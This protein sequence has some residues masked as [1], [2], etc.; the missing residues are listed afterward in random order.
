[1]APSWERILIVFVICCYN[2]VVGIYVSP[3]FDIYEQWGSWGECSPPCGVGLRFRY[4]NCKDWN[5]YPC[6]DVWQAKACR[7]KVCPV[8]GKWSSWNSWT[9]CPV[10]CGS[11]VQSRTR[12]CTNPAPA[13]GG[14]NCEGPSSET[15][16]CA[17]NACPVNGNW[18]AWSS[19]DSCSAT[20]GGGSQSRTRACTNPAPSNGGC[21]C[22]GPSSETQVCATNACPVNGKWSS[23]NSWTR[24]PV[25]CGSGVQ[26]RTRDC[27]RNFG[28]NCEGPSS[29]TQIC[30]TNACPVNGN[31]TA[32]SSWDS[33]SAT[34]GGGSQS[35]TRECTNP[36]PVNGGR[37]CEGPSS[38]TQ[39][40]ATN[41]CPVNGNWT[42]WSSWDSCSATCGGGSQSRTR[43]CTN[44][45]PVNGGSNCEGPSSETQICA[46]NACPV[47]G[48]WTAWSSWDSCSVSCGGGNQ[49]R[50]RTCTNPAPANG[51]QSCE[52]PS[53]Q[54]RIC[55]TD[56]CPPPVC[57]V[58]QTVTDRCGQRC[59]CGA[60][61]N[62]TQCTRI[63]K[64]FTSMTTAER[65]RYISVIKTASTD[66]RYKSRYDTLLT[67]HKTL[68]NNGD[69]HHN[70]NNFLPWH[71]WYDLEYENL[72]REVDCQFTVAYWD[73]VA[74][75]E[76]PWNTR[77]RALW[78]SGNSGMG[79]NGVQPNQC[80]NTG[81]FREG[82]WQLIPSVNTLPRC[83]RRN[84]NKNPPNAVELEALL[85]ISPERFEGFEYKLRY[86]FTHELQCMI[87]GTMCSR[88]AA[89]APEFFL[90]QA[91]I[92]KI[93]E[94][95][96]SKSNFHRTVFFANLTTSLPGTNNILPR[97]LIDNKALP[98]GVRV[99]Y[100]PYNAGLN[101]MA[102]SEDERNTRA[103]FT[104]M[105]KGLV[106]GLIL[107]C[108]I[109]CQSVVSGQ[110]QLYRQWGAWSSCS[111][112]CGG[113]Y[114]WRFRECVDWDNWNCW[115][116]WQTEACNT[117]SCGVVNG[118]WTA[119]SSWSSCSVSCGGGSQSRTRTCT[120]PAPANGGSN[121]DGPSS[122][123]Q[124]C[125]QTT[126]P[127]PIHGNWTEWSSWSS[128]SVSCGG[129]SQSRTRTC[130]NPPPSNGGSNC[131]GPSSETQ[132]CGTITCPPRCQVGQTV[133][134]SC[135]QRCVCGAGG[136]LTQ[137]TR[138]RKEFTSMTTAERERHISVIK[139]A[140]TDPR[141]KPRYDALITMHKEIFFNNGIHEQEH[142]LT[143][144]RWYI[145]T[146]ENLLREVDCNFTVA[147][148]D[149]AAAAGRPWAT[150]AQDVWYS[151]DSGFGGNGV[152]PEECVNTGPFRQGVW[153][154]VPPV[155]TPPNCLKR[156][157]N[158]NPEGTVEIQILLNTAAEDFVDFE[159]ALRGRFH[160]TV[161]CLIGGTMCEQDSAAAPE[162]F[163]HHGFIDKIWEDWQ[164]R[165]A[166]HRN[167]YF[168][169]LNEALPRSSGVLPRE[170]LDN[171]ALPGGVRAEYQ[172]IQNSELANVIS[173]LR[174]LP[175]ARLQAIPRI[176]AS[177]ISEKTKELFRLKA[178]EQKRLEELES[179]F[180]PRVRS[181]SSSRSGIAGKLG[182]DPRVLDSVAK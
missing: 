88:D 182:F 72:L 1:M 15:Q 66:P 127:T 152:A 114:R 153:S 55:A 47:N 123:T 79:G 144:H 85:N 19:W 176:G 118:N 181:R 77:A 29:E 60:G 17:T 9:R 132:E 158:D 8:H 137:C 110:E 16:I 39:I 165:S 166:A 98:G 125:S 45:A 172:P 179:R 63:R 109:C 48:N 163:L 124:A 73:W 49:R 151:G 95:W 67:L 111:E 87:G 157:F 150:G 40:C 168:S 99:E 30:A 136:T 141:Y 58:G 147:Y 57:Q 174:S 62:L 161:H 24:C 33:C 115:D 108:F 64:E 41:A 160:D 50:T 42:A 34:C 106:S 91:M 139:T 142:F 31:W 53:L 75:S 7:V 3:I 178:A 12:E 5:S 112:Q 36:A 135:S 90:L 25:T 101:D 133:T 120:N 59:V 171:T 169:N 11:G 61:G 177:P 175:T 103:V 134:D 164:K 96:Q 26:S 82:I 149:W 68:F 86:N 156:G 52:G 128:C 69:T 21:N 80:V 173:R 97:Q 89:S 10:T 4:R 155:L 146:Y 76:N 126:C 51:G 81:P 180:Q 71:R 18:T 107:L 32:W 113:G 117:Q 37:N 100:A 116:I 170:V 22:E 6:T 43:E 56:T 119:W 130:T 14:R 140:S 44:L 2:V 20:C 167:V 129:G 162:F 104:T 65:Q 70:R 121:C 35:R 102:Y 27:G 78:Y 159:L 83:L 84:F 148:W 94:D 131:D 93:W 54:T 138:I 105:A 145:L 74:V 143:W 28:R 154:L 122:E 23:W 46:T 92:D 38:E 13:N